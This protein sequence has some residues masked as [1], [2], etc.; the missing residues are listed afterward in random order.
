MDPQSA[1]L[2]RDAIEDLRSRGKR[3]IV[4]TTHNLNEAQALADRIAVIRQGRIVTIGSFEQLSHRFVGPPRMELRTTQ[5][6]N[7]L[8]QSLAEMVDIVET[9]DNWL[10]YETATPVQTNPRVIQRVVE[11]GGH[12]LTLSQLS[13]NLEEVYLE[14][15]KEDEGKEADEQRNG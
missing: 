4:L 8:T 6:L 3:T 2:V 9:G 15:V 7:G 1:K 11:L 12:V 10:H 13:K 5:P 14:I